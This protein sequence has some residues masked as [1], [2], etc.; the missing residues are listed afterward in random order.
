MR[1]F[2]IAATIALAATSAQAQERVALWNGLSVGMTKAE[3]K[4]ALPKLHFDIG[5][6]CYVKAEPHF[7]AGALD[8]VRVHSSYSDH[9]TDCGAMVRANLDAKYGAGVEGDGSNDCMFFSG[10]CLATALSSP[11]KNA[12]GAIVRNADHEYT[13]YHNETVEVS[14]R[15]YRQNP[16]SY[17]MIYR[18]IVKAQTDIAVQSKL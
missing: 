17:D 10:S 12:V 16:S 15:Q 1:K 3:V 2:I 4:A 9:G 14:I 13:N 6:G 5:Q 11:L 8:F 18:P 7:T